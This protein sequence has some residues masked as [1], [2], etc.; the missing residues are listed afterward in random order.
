MPSLVITSKASVKGSFPNAVRPTAELTQ[1]GGTSFSFYS[2]VGH[3]MLIPKDMFYRIECRIKHTGS[4]GLTVRFLGAAGEMLKD[5]STTSGVY[6]TASTAVIKNTLGRDMVDGDI[7]MQLRVGSGSDVGN[8]EASSLRAIYAEQV[9]ISD[10]N[11]IKYMVDKIFIFGGAE[12]ILG[13]SGE[14]NI[15]DGFIEIV[16]NSI[17]SDF[18][19]SAN[20]GNLLFTWEGKTIGVSV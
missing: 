14:G 1:T 19:F 2:I 6:V 9:N 11:S 7:T 17:M 15:V 16:V 20:S 5:T 10:L 8:M 18:I 13:I 12:A 4:T 3:G